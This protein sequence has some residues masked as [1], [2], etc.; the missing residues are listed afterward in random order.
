[1]SAV[2]E[3]TVLVPDW[4]NLEAARVAVQ[5]PEDA[6]VLSAAWFAHGEAV[7]VYALTDSAE[8]V[9]SREFL[10]ARR[11][12]PIAIPPEQ[13]RHLGTITRPVLLHVFEVVPPAGTV[14][15]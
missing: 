8:P 10:V 6:Q 4:E 2:R 7:V 12:S 9:Q 15:R 11:D 14:G 13:L 5:L 1:M 3:Y